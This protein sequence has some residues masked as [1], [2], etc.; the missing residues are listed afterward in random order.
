MWRREAAAER[1][2]RVDIE[3]IATAFS[4]HDF[5]VAY[6]HISGDVRWNIVGAS[7]AHG[8][9]ALVAACEGTLAALIATTTTFTSFRALR[10]GNTVVIESVAD[11]T[12]PD[13][14]VATVASCDI[15]DFDTD[16]TVAAITSYTV[17]V[18]PA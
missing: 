4:Q 3:T 17:E 12:E 15:Y 1:S 11:Y 9:D 8:K 7:E 6:P 10:A 16:N 14:S 18:G 5:A 2:T 13:G